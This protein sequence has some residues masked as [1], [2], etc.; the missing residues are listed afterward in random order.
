MKTIAKLI[1]CATLAFAGLVGT[2][3]AA[4]TP[5]CSGSL[6]KIDVDLNNDWIMV[7]ADRVWVENSSGTAV[8][9][10]RIEDTTPAFLYYLGSAMRDSTIL[11]SSSQRYVRVW[12]LPSA[13]G[14][15]AKYNRIV[16]IGHQ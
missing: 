8:T 16:Q 4:T 5:V 15:K 12:Y 6:C 13:Q 14:A 3:Q 11:A 7:S 9:E 2:A 1:L 10:L